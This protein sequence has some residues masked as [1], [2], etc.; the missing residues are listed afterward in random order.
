MADIIYV[1]DGDCALCSRF[2]RFLIKHEQSG[3]L[4][5][6]TAQSATGRAI[7]RDEGLCPDAMETAILLV[8]GKTWINLDLFT[9]GLA[10]CGWPWKASRILHVLP[11]FLS[12]W[13]YRRIA[14]N[15]KRFNGGVCPLPSP[16]MKARLLE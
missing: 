6:A 14:N 5:L 12:D 11:Q 3:T 9:E 13:I 7:Y 15:R 4:K 1:Y 2:V 16:E 8:D 10:L